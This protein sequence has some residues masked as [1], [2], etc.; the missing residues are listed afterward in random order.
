M[1]NDD[2]TRNNGDCSNGGDASCQSNVTL[3]PW[4]NDT[5]GYD[6]DFADEIN[7]EYMKVSSPMMYARIVERS[8][9]LQN[10]DLQGFSEADYLSGKGGIDSLYE[11]GERKIKSGQ[12]RIYG[13]YEMPLWA[14][15]LGKYGIAEQEEITLNFNVSTLTDNLD[16][17]VLHIGDIVK[18]YDTVYGWKYFEIMNAIPN[19]QFLG[20]YLMWQ[21]VAKKTDLEGYIDLETADLEHH[22]EYAPD[23]GTKPRPK[24]Y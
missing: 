8:I 10:I 13:T 18:L 4:Q 16:G 15:E 21:I 6:T 11:E 24:V 20:Q 3:N 5:V 14:Q 9:D 23:E 19:G 2:C 22:D 1:S 17:S 12:Y 7:S